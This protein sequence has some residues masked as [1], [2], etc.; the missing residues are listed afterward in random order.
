MTIRNNKQWYGSVRDL[1]WCTAARWRPRCEKDG[2]ESAREYGEDDCSSQLREEQRRWLMS[3]ERKAIS[4]RNLKVARGIDST[5]RAKQHSL[6]VE[7]DAI[8]CCSVCESLDLESARSTQ[9]A[10]EKSG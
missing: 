9:D 8:R 5:D 2:A 6:A 3:V 7:T 4:S 1:G 10:K